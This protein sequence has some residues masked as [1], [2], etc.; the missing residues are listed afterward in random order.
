MQLLLSEIN[1]S[2]S[3]LTYQQLMDLLPARFLTEA[4]QQIFKCIE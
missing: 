2:I 4:M 3:K 1:S